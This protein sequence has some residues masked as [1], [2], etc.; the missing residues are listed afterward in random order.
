MEKLLSDEEVREAIRQ[1]WD[2]YDNGAFGTSLKATTDF[3]LTLRK[4]DHQYLRET[5]EGMKRG[6]LGI[7]G[8]PFYGSLEARKQSRIHNE[9]L[10]KIL[11]LLTP[12]NN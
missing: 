2:E 6:E 3:I 10:E 9:A 8:T 5:I 1:E 11:T 12:T 4:S 7:E